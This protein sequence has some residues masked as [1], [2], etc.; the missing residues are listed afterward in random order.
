MIQ[1]VRDPLRPRFSRRLR[2]KQK[3]DH[4]VHVPGTAIL[5]DVCRYH[6]DSMS[7]INQMMRPKTK[8]L[9]MRLVRQTC[10]PR[11]RAKTLSM[12]L[13]RQTCTPGTAILGDVCRYHDD[14][15]AGQSDVVA[16]GAATMADSSAVNRF[17][18]SA[19]S[20]LRADTSC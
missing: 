3:T 1:I 13:V 4:V 17:R 11:P 5:G 19:T 15:P 9:S 2:L 6:G 10:T 20:S 7:S 18:S 12:H 8:T 16:A 14:L